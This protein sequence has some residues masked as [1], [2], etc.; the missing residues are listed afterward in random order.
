[1]KGTSK[2]PH[3]E[4]VIPEKIIGRTTVTNLQSGLLYGYVGQVNYIVERMKEE[5]GESQ[6]PVVA[7]GGFAH[8][9]AQESKVID[10]IDGLLTLKGIRMV[11]DKN[12]GPRG[13]ARAV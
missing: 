5:M 11:Y 8:L 9:I 1:M 10:H 7:T 12:F 3:F 13:E 2:L 6:V 4:M